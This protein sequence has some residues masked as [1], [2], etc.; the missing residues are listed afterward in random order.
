MTLQIVFP[1]SFQSLQI[2]KSPSSFPST[3]LNR[4]CRSVSLQVSLSVIMSPTTRLHF[5]D[6]GS[7][8]TPVCH[9]HLRRYTL[10]SLYVQVCF[11]FFLLPP[12]LSL[13]YLVFHWVWES[14]LWIWGITF[15]G[16]RDVSWVWESRLWVWGMGLRITWC[17]LETHHMCFLWFWEFRVFPHFD[18]EP[19]ICF[20]SI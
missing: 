8:R 2:P 10:R 6:S 3:K 15:G 20:S 12:S 1:S 19:L 4:L 7:R 9:V 11:P 14:R 18:N 5:H 13:F 16:Q 17:L